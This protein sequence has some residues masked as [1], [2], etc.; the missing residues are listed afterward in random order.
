MESEIVSSKA[1][2]RLHNVRQL[3]LAHYVFPAANYSRFAHSVGAC[4]NAQRL[5]SAI[6]KNTGMQ[7]GDKDVQLVRLAALVHDLGHYPFSHAFEHEIRDFYASAKLSNGSTATS[8]PDQVVHDHEAMGEQVLQG[9]EEI[10]R[11]L[12]AHKVRAS[13]VSNAFRKHPGNPLAGILSSDLDCDR[14]DYLRRTAHHSGLPYGNVD[15]NYIID[16]ATKDSEGNFCFGKKAIRAADHLLVSRYFD[17]LQVPF[18]K[19]VVSLEW[20]LQVVI[21]ELLERGKMGCTAEEMVA[22]VYD[23]TWRTFDDNWILHAA[24]ELAKDLASHRTRRN[25]RDDGVLAHISAILHRTPAKLIASYEAV[26]PAHAA[27]VIDVAQLQSAID[28]FRNRHGLCEL[29]LNLWKAREFA[30]I[31]ASTRGTG[32]AS[33]LLTGLTP[34]EPEYYEH[35]R[36]NVPHGPAEPISNFKEALMHQIHDFKYRAFRVYALLNNNSDFEKL[37]RRELVPA[38]QDLRLQEA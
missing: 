7:L 17:Y 23:G 11:I 29:S 18:H 8:E 4:H 38:L 14:L 25:R 34:D 19:S 24:R 22:K 16:Q 5:L 12:K 31:K 26:A 10:A 20:S 32:Q 2:Q 37:I 6:S 15:I 21:R 33:M 3:G 1:F 9:D 35:V 30:L 28:D 13:D 27:M 36:I